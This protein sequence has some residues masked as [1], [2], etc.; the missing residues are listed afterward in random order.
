MSNTKFS[1]IFIKTVTTATKNEERKD[2]LFVKKKGGKLLM[3]ENA[4]CRDTGY[5]RRRDLL[6]KVKKRGGEARFVN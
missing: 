3:R 1:N 6:Y 2:M 5:F 4:E